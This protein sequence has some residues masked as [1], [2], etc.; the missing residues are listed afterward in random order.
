MT[1]LA[2]VSRD[3]VPDQRTP[4]PAPAAGAG[5]LDG[6]DPLGRWRGQTAAIKY[7]GSAMER[8]DL[9]TVFAR[10]VVVNGLRVT[11]RV[12]IVDGRHR[13]AVTLGLLG[14]DAPGTEIV[15]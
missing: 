12:R 10:E 13:R 14:T 3:D 9:R 11:A 5:T 7:G 6:P 2:P 15:R 1:S 4:V 8:H